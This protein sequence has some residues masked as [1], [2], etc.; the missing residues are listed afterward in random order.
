MNR[1]I[2][3]HCEFARP[4]RDEDQHGVAVSCFRHAQPVKSL[5]RHGERI[6]IQVPALDIHANL[7]RAFRFRIPNRPYDSVMLEFAQK[8]F[9]PHRYHP[10]P[11][12]PSAEAAA[13]SAKT[14]ETATTARG[15]ATATGRKENRAASAGRITIAPEAAPDSRDNDQHNDK[16][17]KKNETCA[18]FVLL[19]V[20]LL[21]SFPAAFCSPRIAFKIES[22][23]AAKPAW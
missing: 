8:F 19:T 6:D 9:R 16:D 21:D 14:A 3:Y 18:S 13:P 7:T 22:I 4:G 5:L 15:P 17:D 10:E 11:A 2:A 23:P 1:P 12:P 20:V